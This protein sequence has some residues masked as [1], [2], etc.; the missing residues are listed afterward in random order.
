MDRTIVFVTHGSIESHATLKR[1][2]GLAEPLRSL[3]THPVIL[4]QDSEANRRRVTVECPNA[5]VIWYPPSAAFAERDIK[6]KWVRRLEPDVCWICAPGLRNA[7]RP[8]AKRTWIVVD[9][10]ELPSANRSQW[11]P[12][13]VTDFLTERLAVDWCDAH[14]CASRFLVDHFVERTRRSGSPEPPPPLLHLPYAHSPHE[15]TANPEEVAEVR[16]QYGDGR[17]VLYVGTFA[18]NYGVFDLLRAAKEVTE[19]RAAVTFIIAGKGDYG[20]KVADAVASWGLADRVVLPGY[21][22]DSALA[23]HMAAADAFVCPLRDTVQDWARCPSKLYL[24]A[25]HR[26]PIVTCRIGEAWDLLGARGCYFRPSDPRSMAHAIE[27][28]LDD[29]QPALP[30]PALHSWSARAE[31]VASWLEGL[32]YRASA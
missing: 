17:I 20:G 1:A 32:P 29:P 28:A 19:R 21:L 24:Y 25:A 7:V 4:L 31:Q 12:R 16:R 22:P 5:E 27:R 15:A 8:A 26:H 13:R 2:T 11:A 18:E 23:A 9:H 6:E 10:S 30:D 14:V 3:G